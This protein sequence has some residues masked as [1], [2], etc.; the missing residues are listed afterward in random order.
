MTNDTQIVCPLLSI[1]SFSSCAGASSEGFGIQ[2]LD[3][4]HSWWLSSDSFVEINLND[5]S[6]LNTAMRRWEVPVM[7]VCKDFFL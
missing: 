7:Q 2:V 5:E 4:S 6:N 3:S 1:V